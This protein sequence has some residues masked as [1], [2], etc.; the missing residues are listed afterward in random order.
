MNWENFQL[1]YNYLLN[2]QYKDELINKAIGEFSLVLTDHKNRFS[3]FNQNKEDLTKKEWDSYGKINIILNKIKQKYNV[4]LELPRKSYQNSQKFQRKHD[5]NIGMMYNTPAELNGV[6]TT[7]RD[8]FYVPIHKTRRHIHGVPNDYLESYI[9][10]MIDTAVWNKTDYTYYISMQKPENLHYINECAIYECPEKYCIKNKEK[11]SFEK[12]KIIKCNKKIK[13]LNK[14]KE[15][16]SFF[17]KKTHFKIFKYFNKKLVDNF[18]INFPDKSKYITYCIGNCIYS[19]GFIHNGIPNGKQICSE[20]KIIYCRECLKNPYHEGEL[21]K[22]TDEITFENPNDYRKCP[23]CGIWVEKSE[24][25]SHM[26]CICETH[27]CYDCRGILCAN[28]PYYHI[29]SVNNPDTHYR[30]YRFNHPSVQYTGEVACK[31]T[32]CC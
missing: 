20:C 6:N 3:D 27:F 21:C 2:K 29:C 7:D 11:N 1:W 15:L 32:N 24:G 22:F 31:C 16:V 17:S 9:I 19:D 28:D 30:D 12:N 23:G 8:Y 13:V 10:N 5:I 14:I 4:N 26:K 25:C 18:R